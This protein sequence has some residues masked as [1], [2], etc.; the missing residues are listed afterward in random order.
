MTIRKAL[1]IVLIFSTFAQLDTVS[2]MKKIIG[3]NVTTLKKYEDNFGPSYSNSL[4]KLGDSIVNTLKH[5]SCDVVYG[6][7]GD[8]AANI[9]SAIE[10][11][12]QLSPCG[13]EMNAAFTACGQAEISGIGFCL[14]TY[15]V[16]SLP[17]ASAVALAKTEQLPVIFISGAP[18]EDEVDGQ[19][20]HHSVVPGSSWKKDFDLALNAYKSMEIRAERL[21]GERLVGQ[22]NVAGA[23][24]YNLIKHAIVNREPVFIEIPRNLLNCYTQPIHYDNENLIHSLNSDSRLT[25]HK[26]IAK[27]IA[28][29]LNAASQP[30]VYIGEKT[31]LNR[32]LLK[33]IFN[34][35]VNHQIP[36]ATSW[37][38]KGILNESH[39]LSLGAYNGAFS[40]V[41]VRRFIET[42]V[43]YVLELG[44]SIFPQDTNQAFDTG[45]HMIESFDNKTVLK[46]TELNDV[47]LVAV[48]QK[49]SESDIR[50]FTKPGQIQ[51]A[52]ADLLTDQLLGF[53][54]LTATLS[55]TQKKLDRAM[56]YV[57]EIG[58]SYFA[59]YDL[60][61]KASEIGRSWI[62]NPWYA[63]MGTSLC[64]ARAISQKIKNN[65]YSDIPVVL[66]G[67]GGFHFQSNELIHVL[68]EKLSMVVIYMR[69]DIFHL[70]KSSDAEI[71]NCST[72]DFDL[73][74][75]TQAYG[76]L[77]YLCQKPNELSET[78]L[79]LAAQ[80]EFGLVVIE[81]PASTASEHQCREI[82][83]LN[84]YIQAKN[85]NPEALKEWANIKSLT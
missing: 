39:E 44:T 80:D 65:G 43:D 41:E 7:G 17:C 75:L 71:Y 74:K 66:T 23:Q 32:S 18:G 14:T 51:P 84:L 6:V 70:G 72:K 46:G 21:Q 52:E 57:P 15:T 9:I 19:A 68:R 42:R 10:T 3:N 38:A 37:F 50:K 36:Y 76:G 53:H 49:L 5:F 63:A 34:F 26:D 56:V 48:I 78:L 73:E 1:L 79:S 69:N 30:M 58:N 55:Q 2:G 8:F 4:T 59:S 45:T 31:K 12:V 67:D 64:Y 28:D 40:S 11:E 85:A 29:K 25:G 54:N 33:Q 83:L 22:P 13:S 24:F 60:K 47:D 27:H 81:I 61:T 16:G 77:H 35:C 82:K 62:T 20:I